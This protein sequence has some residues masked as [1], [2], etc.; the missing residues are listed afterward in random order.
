MISKN[1]TTTQRRTHIL[2]LKIDDT[3]D[4]LA[5]AKYFSSLDLK[6]GYWQVKMDE[7]LK[8]YTAFT[9]RLLSFY[10]CDRMPFRL[11]NAPATFQ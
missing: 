6:S 5:R 3:M 4:S 10:E 8:K 9:V 11:C 7:E 2:F 1:L